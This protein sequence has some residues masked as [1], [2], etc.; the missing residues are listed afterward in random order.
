MAET[1]LLA[2]LVGRVS[3]A[4]LSFLMHSACFNAFITSLKYQA[5]FETS[6]LTFKI[7]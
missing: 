3:I 4:A 7:S 6:G 1:W 2:V 5:N